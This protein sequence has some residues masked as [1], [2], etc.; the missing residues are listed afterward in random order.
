MQQS[1]DLLATLKKDAAAQVA[2]Y[3]QY[4]GHFDDYVLVT[5]IRQVKTKMGLAFDKNEV[6]IAKPYKAPLAGFDDYR[7]VWSFKNGCDTSILKFWCKD[8]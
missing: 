8:T 2:A 4:S 7:T 3:P 1:I 5:V 6:T